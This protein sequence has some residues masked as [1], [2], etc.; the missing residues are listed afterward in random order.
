MTFTAKIVKKTATKGISAATTVAKTNP[1]F[2][3]AAVAATAIIGSLAPP[4][5]RGFKEGWSSK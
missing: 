5:V 4:F 2:A 1:V 3:V